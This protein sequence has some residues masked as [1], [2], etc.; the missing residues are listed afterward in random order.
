MP[1][2]WDNG[3]TEK[4]GK[5]WRKTLPANYNKNTAQSI[6]SKLMSD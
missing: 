6:Q 2:E 3:L 4:P 5:R 1:I